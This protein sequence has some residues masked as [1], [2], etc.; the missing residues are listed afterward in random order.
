MLIIVG[1][2]VSIIVQFF[3]QK[4]TNV[5]SGHWQSAY[6]VLVTASAYPVVLAR[7]EGGSDVS[8]PTDPR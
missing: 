7:F 8:T 3:K 4:A 5:D 2:V 6:G 1:A